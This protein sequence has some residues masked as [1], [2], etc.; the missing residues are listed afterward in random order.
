MDI[1]TMTKK[2]IREWDIKT[3]LRRLETNEN[4]KK[5]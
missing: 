5:K 1:K 3:V 4:E 2:E